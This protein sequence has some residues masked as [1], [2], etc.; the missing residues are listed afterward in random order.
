MI[1]LGVQAWVAAF[2]EEESRVSFSTEKSPELLKSKDKFL[3]VLSNLWNGVLL[4]NFS[5]ENIRGRCYQLD[6]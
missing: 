6:P 2:H 4:H 3:K 1:S 5:L